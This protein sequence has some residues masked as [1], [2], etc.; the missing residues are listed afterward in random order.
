MFTNLDNIEEQKTIEEYSDPA[1]ISLVF[2]FLNVIFKLS[3]LN[4]EKKKS[5]F[6]FDKTFN[7]YFANKLNDDMNSFKSFIC[8]LSDELKAIKDFLDSDSKDKDF[9]SK[10]LNLD[11]LISCVNNCFLFCMNTLKKEELINS[12]KSSLRELISRKKIQS[13][14]SKA[15]IS[16]FYSGINKNMNY[17]NGIKGKEITHKK[18]TEKNKK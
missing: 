6:I 9:K 15:I 16:S 8:Q 2:E 11:L 14:E 5:K 4:F 13:N 18:L 17:L 7:D 3:L 10:D 1:Y 12:V